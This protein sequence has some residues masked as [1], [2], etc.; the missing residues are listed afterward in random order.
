M[1]L[2]Y[3]V[4]VDQEIPTCVKVGKDTNWPQR[5]KQARCHS[6]GKIVVAATL[7]IPSANRAEQEALD[8]SVK[9]VLSPYMRNVSIGN[10]RVLEW[11]DVTAVEAVRLLL[12]IPA[13]AKSEVTVNPPEIQ[14]TQ[15][16]YEYED[17]RDRGQPQ[18]RW[19]AFL[20]Q[21]LPSSSAAAYPHD[22]RMKLAAGSLYD[23]AY[24]YNF[25]YCPFPVALI[26]GYAGR[27]RDRHADQHRPRRRQR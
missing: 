17:W 16:A 27:G 2:T 12:T 18:Y 8:A 7:Q 21:I 24:R 13:L 6:P 11:Y 20:F 26:G 9:H 15:S 4:L 1:S 22:G 14:F 19:R 3:Y 10:A 25:T 23:T 5:Y